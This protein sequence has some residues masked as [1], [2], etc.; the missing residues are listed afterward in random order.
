[1]KLRKRASQLIEA[2]VHRIIGPV[3]ELISVG[4]ALFEQG[5]FLHSIRVYTRALRMIEG[6]GGADQHED[7]ISC[8]LNLAEAYLHENSE[9]LAEQTIRPVLLKVCLVALAACS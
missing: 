7:Y 6:C 8:C 2:K 1:V 9:T 3:E 4:N 5:Q